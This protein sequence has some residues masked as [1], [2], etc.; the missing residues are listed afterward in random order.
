MDSK[1]G[2]MNRKDP[3]S[4]FLVHREWTQVEL[5]TQVT[6]PTNLFEGESVFWIHGIFG[7]QLYT[8]TTSESGILLQ[9]G[10]IGAM[11]CFLYA[12]AS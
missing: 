4:S 2:I 3:V 11:V 12:T 1:M 5:L 8:K 9:I 10:W 6:L 7:S